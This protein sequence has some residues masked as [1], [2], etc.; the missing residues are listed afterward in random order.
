MKF[1]YEINTQI[2]VL[3]IETKQPLIAYQ[4]FT[5]I[6]DSPVK[7][8]P[9]NPLDQKLMKRV[10]KVCFEMQLLEEDRLKDLVFHEVVIDIKHID[11]I[12]MKEI[13]KIPT[14]LK[15]R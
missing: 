13:R 7:L 1:R 15:N 4:Q 14:K 9:L 12:F 2:G 5:T 10:V 11:H 3:D 8:N 6:Y